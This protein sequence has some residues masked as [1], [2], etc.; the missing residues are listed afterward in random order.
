MIL[1]VVLG[2]FFCCGHVGIDYT[3]DP[4]SIMCV[5]D[6]HSNNHTNYAKSTDE[7]SL[8]NG[9]KAV[10][11]FLVRSCIFPSRSFFIGSS[12]FAIN[13]VSVSKFLS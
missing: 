9:W 4:V 5:R 2:D 8:N 11:L 3:I 1:A 10:L 7:L 6:P 12:T 13:G